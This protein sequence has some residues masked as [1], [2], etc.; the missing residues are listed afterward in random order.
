MF[1]TLPIERL[2]ESPQNVR[3]HWRDGA[4]EE[5]AASIGQV[6]VLTPLLVRPTPIDIVPLS[7]D[8]VA[9]NPGDIEIWDRA[10]NELLTVCSS[11]ERAEAWVRA[12]RES[13][14]AC[15]EIAAGHRR[16]R[17]AQIA[18]LTE[19]PVQIRDLGDREFLEVL[20]IENLQR[21]DVHPLD[22]ADGYAALMSADRAYT[23]EAIAAKV[24]KS[25][26]YVRQRLALRK[27]TET[28]RA[29]YLR[30]EITA[31][32]AVRL[33]RL[34]PQD[35]TRA[36]DEVVFMDL[37]DYADAD[38]KMALAPVGDLANWV[39]RQV[40]LDVRAP[41]TSEQFP[42][43]AA[44]VAAEA[45]EGA[46]VLSLTSDYNAPKTK[47]GPLGPGHFHEVLTKKDACPHTQPGVFVLGHRRGEL[48]HVCAQ[49]KCQQ[50]W[51]TQETNERGP[52]QKDRYDWKAQQAKVEREAKLWALVRP[53]VEAAMVEATNDAQLSVEVVDELL[54]WRF[55]DVLKA[56]G[57][58]AKTID[59]FA[60]PQ[61]LQLAV[62]WP[63]LYSAGNATSAAKKLGVDV[64]AIMRQVEKEQ[65]A[66][67]KAK[68][69][70]AKKTTARKAVA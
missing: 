58:T 44:A 54:G 70:T 20:T 4:L 48:I 15:F 13:D 56:M 45:A 37:F 52:V 42:E 69:A 60:L 59:A 68:P 23:V 1:T 43:I 12:Y 30:D 17:A 24:G 46:M 6:G 14:R 21:E 35:Q 63:S 19:L 41:E 33:A 38:P 7:D 62:V 5:L 28:A 36:L 57:V 18:C 31:A 9:E 32:H 2:I 55:K 40:V 10:A 67:T 64:K 16:F 66:T 50:H 51:P 53:R 34:S 8:V 47:G 25:V 29:I 49:R 11:R 27:L 61:V 26:S 39:K 22:E 3:Q 65:A